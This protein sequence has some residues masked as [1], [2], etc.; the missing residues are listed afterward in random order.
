MNNRSLFWYGFRAN[1][2]K[3]FGIIIIIIGLMLLL[4]HWMIT[5]IFIALGIY[6]IAT[7]SSQR[8]DYQRQSGL[9]VHGGD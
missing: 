9:I 8:F 5:L 2:K 3:T 6:L 1:L 4:V 7:G